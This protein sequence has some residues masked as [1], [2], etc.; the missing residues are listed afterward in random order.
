MQ[1]KDHQL[2]KMSKNIDDVAIYKY[3][4]MIQNKIITTNAKFKLFSPTKYIINHGHFS[5][6]NDFQ[7]KSFDVWKNNNMSNKL[8]TIY[9]DE[10]INNKKTITNDLIKELSDKYQLEKKYHIH[11][12]DDRQ[13]IALFLYVFSK[14]KRVPVYKIKTNSLT[15]ILIPD[16]TTSR[17]IFLKDTIKNH[18]TINDIDW[19]NFKNYFVYDH[20]FSDKNY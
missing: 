9:N 5:W 18:D 15:D 16:L 4:D 2:L 10:S 13:I 14:I 7:F 11:R 17:I 20:N 12:M 3:Y 1:L 19:V 8:I 6:L